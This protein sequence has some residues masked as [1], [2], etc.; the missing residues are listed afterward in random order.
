VTKRRGRFT[1]GRNTYDDC[2]QGRLKGLMIG[3]ELKEGG[4]VDSDMDSGPKIVLVKS[5]AMMD[6]P[7]LC[8]IFSVNESR[9]F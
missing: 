4:N 2:E 8:N 5:G 7:C 6:K 9:L 1:Q 3:K